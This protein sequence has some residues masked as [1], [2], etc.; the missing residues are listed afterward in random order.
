MNNNLLFDFS[1]N[2]ENKSIEVK[3]EFAA[4]VS[5]VWDA[6]TKSDLL[7]KWWAPKP[8][9]AQTKKIDFREGGI[10]HYATVGPNGETHWSL[11][12]YRS[13]DPLKGFTARDGFTNVEGNINE[14][15]PKA[16]WDISFKSLNNHTLVSFQMT[17]ADVNHLETLIKMG[18]KEGLTKGLQQLD[19][20]LPTL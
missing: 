19:E 14:N 20:L 4:K 12:T 15:M 7:D 9:K 8:W 1:V 10:W 3:R 11:V 17:F 5:L 18:F 6:F 13:I 2:K 16:N